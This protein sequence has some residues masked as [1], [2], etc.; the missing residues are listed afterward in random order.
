MLK[1]YPEPD[2]TKTVSESEENTVPDELVNKPIKGIR[3][4]R[5]RP[6]IETKKTDETNNNTK[7]KLKP[8]Q[9]NQDIVFL[10]NGYA[11]CTKHVQSKTLFI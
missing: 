4:R 2:D 1:L 9:K 8:A 7:T 6:Q 3:T 5:K 11:V 10:N